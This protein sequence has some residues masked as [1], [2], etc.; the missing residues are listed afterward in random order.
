M[1]IPTLTT[2]RLFLR[3][4]TPEDAEALFTILQEKDL[5]RYFPRTIPPPLD[6]VERY[7]A[8]HLAQWQERGYGHWAVVLHPSN[9]LIGWNG[10][11]Y[12]PETSETEVA[13]LLSNKYWG[14][15]F[16]TEAARAA[17]DYGFG[18]VGLKQIIG[19][20]HPENI[21]SQRVLEKC[22]LAFIDRA[23]YFGMELCRYRINRIPE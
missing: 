13:Y 9:Q 8:H 6:R 17:I 19:L 3:A 1:N 16:A 11:E 22:G 2:P 18:T 7:I 21:A 14:Q 4:W 12:L 15:G 10:L 20:T 23:L 5:L